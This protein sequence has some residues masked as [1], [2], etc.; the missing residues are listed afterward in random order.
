LCCALTTFSGAAASADEV[1]DLLAGKPVL[2]VPETRPAA[3]LPAPRFD[4]PSL[5]AEQAAAMHARAPWEV[6]ISNPAVEPHVS[7]PA[8]RRLLPAREADAITMVPEPAAFALAA[9]ALVYFLIF[10]RRRHFV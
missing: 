5:S 1:D 4:P 3:P 8:T 9:A 7:K 6:T 2:V 10:F